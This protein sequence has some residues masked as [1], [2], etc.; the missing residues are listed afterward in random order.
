[1]KYK[2]GKI[3]Y[4]SWALD[5]SKEPI[6]TVPD[7]SL[8]LKEILE[9]FTRGE[10]PEVGHPHFF[11]EE[12]DEDLQKLKSLDLVDKYAYIKSLNE[13]QSQYEKEEKMREEEQ[14]KL[15]WETALE[16]ARKKAAEQP[17]K[18]AAEQP[19]AV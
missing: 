3:H 16:E 1:M 15:A 5:M 2:K 10:E 18:K 17:P 19:S 12:G 6:Q 7:Q 13:I 14:K 8:S 9:R 11:D 4:D